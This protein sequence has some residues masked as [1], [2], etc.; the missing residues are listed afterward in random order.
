MAEVHPGR[1][2]VVAVIDLHSHVL[3]GIDDGAENVRQSVA[4]ARAAVADGTTTLA[5]TPHVRADHPGVRPPELPDRCRALN[6]SLGQAG[7]PVEVVSGG[8][9][10]LD[11]AGGASEEAL[12]LVS[13]GQRGSDLLVET[14]YAAL[15]P[16]FEERLFR[17]SSLGFRI[18]LAHPERNSTLQ[19]EPDRVAELVRRGVLIQLTARTLVPGEG[20]SRARGLATDLLREGLAHVLASDAHSAGP[21]APPDISRGVAVAEEA[22][23][24]RARWMVTDAPAAILEGEPLPRPPSS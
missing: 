9:V 15:S 16:E 22:V 18:L 10:D 4:L 14:P 19:E 7:V 5:A 17:L 23:G 11:W 24:A 13:Y 6:E 12:R 2:S 20:S 21:P 8:E 1:H 3:P